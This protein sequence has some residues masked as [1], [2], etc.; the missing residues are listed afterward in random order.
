MKRASGQRSRSQRRSQARRSDIYAYESTA[1]RTLH[2]KPVKRPLGWTH[3]QIAAVGIGAC[4]LGLLILFFADTRFYVRGFTLQGNER[5]DHT[6]VAEM[7]AVRGWSVF[8]I[9]PQ[10]LEKSIRQVPAIAQARVR[11]GLPNQVVVSIQERQPAAVWE[12]PDGRRYLVDK[13]GLVL[14]LAEGLGDLVLIINRDGPTLQPG[15]E[16]DAQ[17]I[18]TAVG[19]GALLEDRRVFHYSRAYGVSITDTDGCRIDF[20]LGGNLGVKVT[21]WRALDAQLKTQPLACLDY[22]DV[23]YESRLSYGCGD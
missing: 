6:D 19:L 14:Q 5:F 4:M 17:V 13:Q 22:I 9:N 3:A 16:I 23:R 11:C 21:N 18:E 12:T 15:D 1:N 2:T 10:Q 8:Y 7:I 20:G